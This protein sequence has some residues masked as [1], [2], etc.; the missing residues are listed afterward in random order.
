M[1][2]NRKL[3]EDIDYYSETLR[4]KLED[5]V[6]GWRRLSWETKV[7]MKAGTVALGI[8]AAYLVYYQ[9][10]GALGGLGRG[11]LYLLTMGVL[12]LLFSTL[13]EVLG[14]NRFKY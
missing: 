7:Q 2:G 1:S 11:A 10:W 5:L 13:R 9:Y 3:R 14:L 12:L 8:G 4:A 6:G